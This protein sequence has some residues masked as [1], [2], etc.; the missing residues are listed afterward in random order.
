[1]GLT[2]R[3]PD[4]LRR[5]RTMRFCGRLFA[6]SFPGHARVDNVHVATMNNEMIFGQGKEVERWNRP[7]AGA[8]NEI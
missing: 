1:V 7:A 3:V 8:A 5:D 2:S 4:G 6:P